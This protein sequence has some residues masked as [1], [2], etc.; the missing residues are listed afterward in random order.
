MLLHPH[1]QVIGSAGLDTGLDQDMVA[2][3]Q[4]G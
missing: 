2:P 4:A 3:A 1:M